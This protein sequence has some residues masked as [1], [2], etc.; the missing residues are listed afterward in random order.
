[1]KGLGNYRF[2]RSVPEP[3]IE[4]RPAILMMYRGQVA[5]VRFHDGQTYS[6][7]AAPLKKIGVEPTQRFRLLIIRLGG[8]VQ[9]VRVEPL[10][11]PR[12]ARAMQT[13]PKV[14]VRDGRKMTTRK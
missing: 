2:Q 11:Q 6:I 7:P 5:V 10:V 14:Q 3:R 4:R 12:P 9:D 8:Q 13:M 1:V